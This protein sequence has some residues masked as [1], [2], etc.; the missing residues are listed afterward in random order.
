VLRNS[1]VSKPFLRDIAFFVDVNVFIPN[2]FGKASEQLNA[3]VQRVIHSVVTPLHSGVTYVSLHFIK[4]Y[5]DCKIHQTKF[6]EWER[7]K[8]LTKIGPK[9]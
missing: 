1:A 7:W 2:P 6:M 3:A 8:M 9:T 4:Y 5:P